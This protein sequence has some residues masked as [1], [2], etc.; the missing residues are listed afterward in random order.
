MPAIRYRCNAST[1]I[2][3]HTRSQHFVEVR[4]RLG[5]YVPVPWLGFVCQK[6]VSVIGGD[7]YGK[8]LAMSVSPDDGSLG[9]VWRDLS[10]GS[11][12]VCWRIPY[13][14]GSAGTAVFGL[15]DASGW[16]LIV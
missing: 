16:P 5:N 2:A 14:E 11:H 10:A 3:N 15:I 9:A 13:R 7:G 12:V 4:T 8:V 1:Q 6:G